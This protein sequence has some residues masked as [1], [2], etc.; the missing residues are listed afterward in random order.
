MRLTSPLRYP[1]GK[2]NLSPFF[3]KVIETNQII[4]GTYIEPY[5]GG[6]SVA[7]NLLLNDYVKNIIINDLDRSI[8]AF[9]HTVV[10]HNKE[11]CEMIR[12]VEVTPE[13]WLI[14]K[15]VQRTKATAGLFE[16]GFSTFF[17]NRT[18]R[19]G[20]LNAWPIG[21]IQ[22]KGEWKIDARFNKEKL[23]KRIEDIG[24]RSEAIKVY[25]LDA[26]NLLTS[27][28]KAIDTS[29]SLIYLDPPYYNKGPVLYMNHYK[30]DDHVELAEI[31]SKIDHHWVIS[32]DKV[33][34]IEELYKKYHS[35]DLILRY[36]ARE[37]RKG[38]E[39]MFFNHGLQIPS[40]R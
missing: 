21:G 13:Q 38:A 20:I 23:I 10:D 25:N 33:P 36:S 39:I 29:N 40:A 34:E 16:L 1:G 12:T 27:T 35:I 3:I 28:I 9:W 5:A 26:T 22:Q 8:Y 15:G 2:G 7:L 32:Y 14:Q 6:A 24:I 19:S 11:L 30:P 4:G 18:N 31:I 17:L 37:N